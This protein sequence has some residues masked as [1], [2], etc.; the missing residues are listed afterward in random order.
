[1]AAQLAWIGAAAIAAGAINAIAAGGSL[2]TF[3]AL[4]AAGVSPVTASATNTV[5]MCGGYLGGTFAQ[6][7]D[8]V[9]QR[10]RA[11]SIIP[12]AVLGGL[13]GALLLLVTGDATF[14]KLVPFLLAFAALLLA[15]QD[16]IRAWIAARGHGEHS[17]RWVH[18]PIALAA[19]Y[20]GY[21]GAGSSVIIL[22]ILA[23][24][25]DDSLIR[26]NALKQ[27]TSS[28][29]NVVAAI[30]FL[31]TG[32]AALDAVVVMAIGATIGG[33]IGGALASRIP[34]RMLR[35]LVVAIAL[36]VAVIYFVR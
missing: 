29:L 5:A 25:I 13:G 6:R 36:V 34:S 9:G 17:E 33:F 8:L 23:A 11:L 12:A 1:M 3:P 22:G 30:V 20:G 35:W 28:V 2:I 21:F 31:A 10:A 4:I 32:R 7:R 24:L 14:A 26:L 27:F 18:L 15:A 19:V 16:R